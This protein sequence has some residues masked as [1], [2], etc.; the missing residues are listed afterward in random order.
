MPAPADHRICFVGDSF[1]LGTGDDS[2]LGW[3]GRL[4]AAARRAGHDITAYNL[5]VR[6]DTSDLIRIRWFPECTSRIRRDCTFGTVFS[7]GANDM[8]ME[9]GALRVAMEDSVANFMAIM[10]GAKT[11]GRVLAVGP[12]PVND[13]AQ[14]RRIATLCALYAKAAA[15]AGVP[16]LPLAGPLSA[17]ARWQRAVVR[18]DG[19]HPDGSGY[20]LIAGQVL[21]WP[22]WWFS[23]PSSRG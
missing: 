14:D 4:A 9:D 3:T 18:G 23:A 22:A 2:G 5:G 11:L 20:E 17:D 16:Y 12:A 15:E 6:R 10:A 8:H 1:V 21:R 7:F 19:T 13:P